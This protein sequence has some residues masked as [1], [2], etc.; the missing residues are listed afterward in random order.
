MP[1]ERGGD[2]ACLAER[3][4]VALADVV[5]AEQLHHDVMDRVLA[6]L[7]E[8]KA[9]M[10][11]IEMKEARDEGMRVIIGQPE[12]ERIA[13]ERHE[14]VDRLRSVD[15]EHDVAEAQRTG[16]KARKIERPGLNGSVAVS[17]P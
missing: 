9:V 11:W 7:D 6:G 8:S 10:P 12:A 13:I 14:P 15:I 16:A 1:P 4:I 17:A 2:A 3:D 5:E